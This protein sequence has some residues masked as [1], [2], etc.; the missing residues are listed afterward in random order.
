M[1]VLWTR[2]VKATHTWATSLTRSWKPKVNCT[3]IPDAI[4]VLASHNIHKYSVMPHSR[5]QA[6]LRFPTRPKCD[7]Q[8]CLRTSPLCVYALPFLPRVSFGLSKVHSFF[9]HIVAFGHPRQRAN[10]MSFIPCGARRGQTL[11]H[12]H[13]I[14]LV[15]GR[16]TC[17]APRAHVSM[18]SCAPH[19]TNTRA[20][21]LGPQVS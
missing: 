7:P 18:D 6:H 14:F 8:T 16:S 9:L 12:R 13:R 5:S 2:G 4:I 19:H 11:L 20:L 21:G 1:F 17:H 10:A 3:N 15:F